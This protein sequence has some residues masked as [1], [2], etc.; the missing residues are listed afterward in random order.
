VGIRPKL[1]AGKDLGKGIQNHAQTF[2]LFGRYTHIH[3]A[4]T[5]KHLHI[6]LVD[7]HP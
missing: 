7:I 4:D 5:Y 3:A 2:Y 6:L 1:L